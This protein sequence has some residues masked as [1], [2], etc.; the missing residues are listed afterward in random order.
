MGIIGLY[1]ENNQINIESGKVLDSN[2]KVILVKT[3]DG[4]IEI[5]QHEFK[6]LPKIGEY[7]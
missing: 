4:A 5:L 2:E 7:L 1:L 6:E 3:Y